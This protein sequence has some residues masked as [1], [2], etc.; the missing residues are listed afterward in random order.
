MAIVPFIP[1]TID[2]LAAPKIRDAIEA[3]RVINENLKAFL[4]LNRVESNWNVSKQIV[5]LL[6]DF[7][8]PIL[9]TKLTKKAAYVESPGIGN[10]VHKLTGRKD[11]LEP[12]ISE[13]RG[14]NR[15]GLSIIER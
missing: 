1:G 2:A 5:E 11:K 10:S 6:P 7:N 3:S 12:V 9:D 8:M 13:N 15:R 14:S 4:L